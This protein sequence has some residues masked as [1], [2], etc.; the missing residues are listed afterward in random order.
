MNADRAPPPLHIT[1]PLDICGVIDRLIDDR[2]ILSIL[3]T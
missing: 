1:L 2:A 3:R